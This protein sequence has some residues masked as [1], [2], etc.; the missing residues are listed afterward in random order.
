VRQIKAVKAFHH[1]AESDW[2]KKI[3]TLK[4]N[5][6]ILKNWYSIWHNE[7]V[8]LINHKFQNR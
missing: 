5:M 1:L 7:I 2:G 6:K 4:K 8:L 3:F